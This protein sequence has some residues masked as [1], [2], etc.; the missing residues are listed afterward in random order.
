MAVSWTN[1][2]DPDAEVITLPFHSDHSG[3]RATADSSGG[4]YY[5]NV[6]TRQRFW[7]D[8][9]STHGLAKDRR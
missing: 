1:P 2:D 9:R 6:K 7:E 4:A 5:Y 3:W 8:P